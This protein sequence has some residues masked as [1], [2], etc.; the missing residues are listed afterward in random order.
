MRIGEDEVARA[1]GEEDVEG[2]DELLARVG[3]C[4]REGLLDEPI[5]VVD[6]PQEIGLRF[7][8]IADLVSS[9]V[10]REAEESLAVLKERSR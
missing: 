3:E 1:A 7:A 9:G 2:V 10:L 4:L 5:D 6:D 8:Q